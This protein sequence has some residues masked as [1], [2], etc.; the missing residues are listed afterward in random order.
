MPAPYPTSIGHLHKWARGL[1]EKLGFIILAKSHKRVAKV[2]AYF[3][4]LDCI[5]GCVAL[6]IKSIKDVDRKADLIILKDNLLKLRQFA[7][8]S[9]K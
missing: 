3:E 2:A 4:S 9:F 8:V 5:M 6:K 7:Q 1:F